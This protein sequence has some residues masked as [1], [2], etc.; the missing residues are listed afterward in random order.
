[1][2]FV[3]AL[4]VGGAVKGV[5]GNK[6]WFIRRLILNTPYGLTINLGRGV[7]VKITIIVNISI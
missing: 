1:M 2:E 6:H 3:T 5:V 7:I 4:V